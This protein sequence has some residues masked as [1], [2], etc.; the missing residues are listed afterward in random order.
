MESHNRKKELCGLWLKIFEVDVA[1]I[2]EILERLG[3]TPEEQK[4]MQ[5]ELT[6]TCFRRHARAAKNTTGFC[7]TCPRYFGCSTYL[8]AVKLNPPVKAG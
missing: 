8:E 4:G 6:Y 3:R 7:L 2:N 5:P 1:K